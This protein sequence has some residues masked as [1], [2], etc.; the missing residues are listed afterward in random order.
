MAVPLKPR[1][2]RLRYHAVTV[3]AGADACAQAKALK[4]VRLL[5]LEAPRLPIV[6]CTS[7][8]GCKCR[9]QHHADRRA[10]PRRSGLRNVRTGPGT[11]D[12]NRRRLL[13]RRDS[14]YEE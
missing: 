10:G 11:A 12:A 4:D 14:D 8:E 6:G 1:P 5:S 13:G 3:M 2:L 9:F 7:P